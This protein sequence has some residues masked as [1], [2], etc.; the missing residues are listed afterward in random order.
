MESQNGI[1]GG[2]RYPVVFHIKS[3]KHVLFGGH[4]NEVANVFHALFLVNKQ[5]KGCGFDADVSVQIFFPDGLHDPDV[6][7]EEEICFL[8]RR[9]LFTQHIDGKTGAF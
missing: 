8:H 1:D 5:A 6:F 7:L 4:L 9:N 2:G 3:N